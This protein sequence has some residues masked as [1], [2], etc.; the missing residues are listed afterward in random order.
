MLSSKIHSPL[1]K[2]T[3]IYK[4]KY[5]LVSGI[6]ERFRPCENVDESGCIASQCKF[7]PSN[8]CTCLTCDLLNEMQIER[9]FKIYGTGL[10]LCLARANGWGNE[11]VGPFAAC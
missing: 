11:L 3:T 10:Q 4:H 2:H 5:Y 8:V 9:K 1:F 7:G 6:R